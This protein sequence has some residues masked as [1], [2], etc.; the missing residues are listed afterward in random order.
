MNNV[1]Q[2]GGTVTLPGESDKVD[3]L[4]GRVVLFSKP[5]S[6]PPLMVD[7]FANS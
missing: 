5:L 4:S 2:K 7:W 1:K 6:Q 3:G